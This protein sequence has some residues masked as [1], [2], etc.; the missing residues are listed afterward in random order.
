MNDLVFRY[1]L[2][3][4]WLL[5]ALEIF[6]V[7]SVNLVSIPSKGGSAPISGDANDSAGM[8]ILGLLD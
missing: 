4:L 2:C 7:I 3:S 8:D 1:I 5:R 6:G